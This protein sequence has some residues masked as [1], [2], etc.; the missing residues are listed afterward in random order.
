MAKRFIENEGEICI[1]NDESLDPYIEIL[2]IIENNEDWLFLEALTNFHDSFIFYDCNELS[3]RLYKYIKK[4]GIPYEIR[5]KN[6][7]V[8]YGVENKDDFYN[9]QSPILI[10]DETRTIKKNKRINYTNACY[11]FLNT[12]FDVNIFLDIRN[13]T[14]KDFLKKETFA[15][16]L[17][18]H[19]SYISYLSLTKVV[20]DENVPRLLRKIRKVT[21]KEIVGILCNCQGE[22][23]FEMLKRQKDFLKR[24]FIILFPP[25]YYIR[26]NAIRCICPDIFCECDV[27]I[28]QLIRKTFSQSFFATDNIIRLLKQSCKKIC[29]HDLYFNGYYPQ[30][31]FK[32]VKTILRDVYGNS[33]FQGRDYYIEEVY[34]KTGSIRST[35]E[36]LMGQGDFFDKE[37]I[38]EHWNLAV[39]KILQA[40][41]HLI[42]IKMSDD[43]LEGNKVKKERLFTNTHSPVNKLL[44]IEVKKMLEM[45]SIP[46]TEFDYNDNIASFDGAQQVIYPYVK[47]I[48]ELDF[49][50]HEVY[51]NKSFVDKKF[52]LEEYIELYIRNICKIGMK[53]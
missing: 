38:K 33:F 13:L 8:I 20:D 35:I 49:D 11:E 39:Y 52:S 6:W 12:I 45:L 25:I 29:I 42:D 50:V 9:L 2:K 30:L 7:Q 21:S 32:P 18:L 43:I 31:S 4:R 22:I 36:I 10:S 40:E 27:F 14:I 28:Y 15:Q 17:C 53:K 44:Y 16:I 24:Y 34:S 26:N 19:V 41:K 5:N 51:I 1:Y 46:F 3:Y 37:K 23:I 47:E 48:L